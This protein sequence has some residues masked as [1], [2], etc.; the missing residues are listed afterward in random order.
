M[1]QKKDHASHNVVST[2]TGLD[3]N[4]NSSAAQRLRVL[5]YLR[6]NGSLSTI[7]ARHC[8][9]VMH[10]AMRVLELRR[11]G[12]EVQTVWSNEF[13]PEGRRHRIARYFLIKEASYAG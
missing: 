6:S 13:T 2:T 12:H 7:E 10:P 11:A 1:T 3:S 8:I 5:T 9:D 4:A